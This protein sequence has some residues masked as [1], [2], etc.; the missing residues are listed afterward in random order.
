MAKNQEP[1]HPILAKLLPDGDER[2]LK[3]CG[4]NL[5]LSCAFVGWLGTAEFVVEEDLVAGKEKK[6]LVATVKL[7]D[8]KKE[9]KK[10]EKKVKKE[11]RKKQGG[12][13]KPR[14]KGDPNATPS[15]G[16]LKILST[17]TSASG[18]SAYNLGNAKFQKDLNKVLDQVAGLQTTGDTKL[19]GRKGSAKGGFNDGYAEGGSGG[20][21]DMLGGLLGGG[22][23]S[24]STEAKGRIKAPS[25]KEI[26]MGDGDGSRSKESIMRVVRSKQ[27][28]LRFAY[29]KY[30]KTTPGMAGVVTVKFTITPQG[31]VVSATVVKSTTGN[32]EF[33]SDILDKVKT[34]KWEVI[35]GGNTPVTIPLTFS[36]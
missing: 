34:W 1:M 5:L 32:S 29:N 17:K 7:E 36:E 12:G 28:G 20:I 15:R 14:G 27:G 18:F 31:D 30:L 4:I 6:E 35:K 8:E 3:F 33:D 24:I 11:I 22:G 9:E 2:L 13:G 16:V 10:E 26:D 19:G 21:G 25:A 23:G